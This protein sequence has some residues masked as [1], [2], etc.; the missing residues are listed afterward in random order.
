MI[1]AASCAT[2][3]ALSWTTV[4]SNTGGPSYA[5]RQLFA[6]HLIGRGLELG[7]LHSP[8]TA[9][10][11]AI[12]TEYVDRWTPEEAKELFPE[13]GQVEFTAADHI[14]DLN[15]ERLS[16]IGDESQ[17]FVIASHVLEH[18]A[19][20]LALLVDMHRVLRPGGTA[21]ILLPDMR[22][23][24]DFR[25]QPTT[26]EHLVDEYERDVQE[27]DEEHLA[28]Y[29]RNVMH[30]EGEGQERKEY[31]ARL[32]QRSI[33]VHAWAEE[34]FFAALR[35]AVEHLGCRFEVLELLQTEEYEKNIEFGYVLRR[36]AVDVTDAAL[37]QRLV[38]QKA[39]MVEYRASRGWTGTD[40]ERR[41]REL[42]AALGAA[43]RRNAL[44]QRRLSG[45]EAWLGPRRRSPVWP[46]AR[47][48]RRELAKRRPGSKTSS[49]A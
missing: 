38:E 10:L 33:H 26:V 37:A 42:E 4:T 15:T 21:I 3:H 47:R 27:V 5:V 22:R 23:M 39:L 48:A 12:E 8:Y 7:A 20:P 30:Y 36:T 46:V 2:G 32:A 41:I 18:V 14:A 25:R 35:H 24:S 28:E 19:N 49:V 9:P 1:E 11:S 40:G 13:L 45:Y 44:L 6:R 17:D 16:M 31:L 43:E 29:A 34:D